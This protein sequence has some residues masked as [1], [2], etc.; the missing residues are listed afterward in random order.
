MKI[1]LSGALIKDAAGNQGNMVKKVEK[2]NTNDEE[3]WGAEE[4]ENRSNRAKNWERKM[5]IK[6]FYFQLHIS[7]N[8]IQKPERIREFACWQEPANPNCIDIL[9]YV[10]TQ[11]T[12]WCAGF[13]VRVWWR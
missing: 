1:R 12:D 11:P 5:F 7:H 4:K 6:P 3:W 10:L 13:L 8:E 2:G 9:K